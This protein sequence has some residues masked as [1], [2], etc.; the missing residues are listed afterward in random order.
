MYGLEWGQPAII[1]EALAQTCVHGV[2]IKSFLL[3]A[4]AAAAKS[5]PDDMPSIW[6]LYEAVKA[7]SNLAGSVRMAD[8]NK[9]RDGVLV[10]ARPDMVKVAARVKVKPEEL[11]ERT[12]EMYNSVVAMASAAA[13]HPPNYPKF[14]FFLM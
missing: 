7:D 5:S 11:E 8:A 6:S 1:A 9:V 10:R 12:V 4:E 13:I 14:D 3:E 2:D